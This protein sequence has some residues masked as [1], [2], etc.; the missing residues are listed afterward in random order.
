MCSKHSVCIQQCEAK[1]RKI[2]STACV[3]PY[4]LKGMSGT[5]LTTFMSV[6]LASF[7]WFFFFLRTSVKRSGIY[8]HREKTYGQQRGKE[9][10][11]ELGDWD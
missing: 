10:W 1:Q 2:L 5:L 8:R 6:P 9:R 4:T 11:D 3:D 7:F